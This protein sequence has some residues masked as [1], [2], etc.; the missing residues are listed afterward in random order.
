MKVY[1]Y[2]F[3]QWVELRINFLC[4]MYKRESLFAIY[5]YSQWVEL[6]MNILE[7]NG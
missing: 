7:G 1:L 4:S 5:N 3:S 6:N 2:N